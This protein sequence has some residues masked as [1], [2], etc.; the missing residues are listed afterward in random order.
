LSPTSSDYPDVRM[1]G[2]C[3]RG[4]ERFLVFCGFA[5]GLCLSLHGVQANQAR[6]NSPFI[7]VLSKVSS[8][9]RSPVLLSAVASAA[10]ASVFP[11]M[12][13]KFLIGVSM[14]HASGG[15]Y[16]NPLQHDRGLTVSWVQIYTH[17]ILVPLHVPRSRRI[18]EYIMIDDWV[19]L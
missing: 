2:C 16:G 13:L 4:S 9:P 1:R 14:C 8:L 19:F 5:G 6:T 17:T 3:R 15:E 18:P 11:T 12:A 10:S 7:R